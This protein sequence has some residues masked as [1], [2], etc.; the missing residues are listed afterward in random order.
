[1]NPTDVARE[2]DVA[3]VPDAPVIQPIQLPTLMGVDDMCRAFDISRAHCYRLA[4]QGRF[5]SFELKPRI[6]RMK[7]SGVKVA[8]YLRGE[9]VK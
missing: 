1:M 5:K 3:S 6:G 9:L 2:P 8:A 4:K 7:W